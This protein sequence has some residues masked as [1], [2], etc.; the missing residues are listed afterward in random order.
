MPGWPGEGGASQD[1]SL[2]RPRPGTGFSRWTGLFSKNLVRSSDFFRLFSRPQGTQ[3]VLHVEVS[4]KSLDEV[5]EH[6]AS[7][8]FR[9]KLQRLE[10]HESPVPQQDL[11]EVSP[12]DRSA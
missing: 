11:V 7:L 6:R 12:P 9:G 1:P 5:I 3:Q 4:L 10:R 2:C 8:H